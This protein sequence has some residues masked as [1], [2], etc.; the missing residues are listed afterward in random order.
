MKQRTSFI[1][2]R[3]YADSQ[4]F[5]PTQIETATK[6]Q[7]QTHLD[8]TDDEIKEYRYYWLG[9]KEILLQDAFARQLQDRLVLFKTRIEAV[10]S[11]AAGLTSERAKE[12]ASELMPYL[13]GE[14]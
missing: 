3:A 14:I 8:L 6:E 2:L 9:M 13:Y 5:T 1:K 4:E 7:T 11:N 10:Y 12:L